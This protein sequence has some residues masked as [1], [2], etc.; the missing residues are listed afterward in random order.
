MSENHEHHSI[1]LAQPDT[2]PASAVGVLIAALAIVLAVT[3]YLLWIYFEREAEAITHAVVLAQPSEALQK[4]R[5]TER[6]DLGQAAAL[7]EKVGAYR[8]PVK[9]AAALFLKE[10]EARR[11]QG[12]PQ[13]IEA[14]SQP[15][16]ADGA[17]EEATRP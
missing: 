4:L 2:T 7:D 10:A 9:Q 11:A 13:R 8:I 5:E 16:H 1:A 6:S 12:L 14:T 15:V 17:A 3:S